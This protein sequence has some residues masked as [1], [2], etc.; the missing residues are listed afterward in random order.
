L[1]PSKR[2]ALNR[3]Y[4]GLAISAAVSIGCLS[5]A[6][7]YH[8]VRDISYGGLINSLTT[9]RATTIAAALAATTLSFAVGLANDFMA[10]RYARAR[11]PIISTI[12][13][14]FCGNAL[15][16][17]IGF[18]LLSGGAVRYRFYAATGISAGKI[19]R[20]TLYIAV[21]F[22]IGTIETIGLGL[23]LR[24][25]EIARLYG[26]PYG[27]LRF[28][29]AVILAAAVAMLI[30]CALGPR[31]VRLGPAT[32]ELPS[33]PLVFIQI[34]VTSCDVVIASSVL[35][36]L[37]PSSGID[38]LAFVVIYALALSLGFLSHT[39]GGIGVFEAAVFYAIG[40]QSPPNAVAA[41]LAA[42]RTIY[43]LSPFGIAASLLAASELRRLRRRR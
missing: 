17:F 20:I 41:A 27:L 31:H 38:F 9:I 7:L 13:A 23:W 5:V 43:S 6:A 2:T 19:A 32:I 42:Y 21:A 37:L 18:G 15:G 39:P 28:I 34:I 40:T 3:F 12:L 35:W 4:R 8:A 25:H 30:S 26:M 1:L 33:L 11:S 16:N 36:V 10:L 24:A 14:S 29:A 22:G